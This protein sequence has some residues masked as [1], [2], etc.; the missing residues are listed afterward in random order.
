MYICI[1]K[2]II[3]HNNSFFLSLYFFQKNDD[4]AEAHEAAVTKGHAASSSSISKG[5]CM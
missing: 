4:I 1:N 3:S 2:N 5:M